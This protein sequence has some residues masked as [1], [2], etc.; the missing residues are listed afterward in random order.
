MLALAIVNDKKW[1]V[2]E[3]KR[4]STQQEAETYRLNNQ[5]RYMVELHVIDENQGKEP[6][7]VKFRFW[8]IDIINKLEEELI[9]EGNDETTADD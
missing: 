8:P 5:H 7:N 2:V 4:F 3:T 9:L 1:W 6:T